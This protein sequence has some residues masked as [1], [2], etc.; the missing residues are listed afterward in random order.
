MEII[1]RFRITSVPELPL[2]RMHHKV[3]IKS[4][5]LDRYNFLGVSAK[6]ID[7]CIQD[8]AN[9]CELVRK[10]G[11][12]D[13]NIRY[14][15]TFRK[16]SVKDA[17]QLEIGQVCSLGPGAISVDGMELL[18]PYHN[19][20]LGNEENVKRIFLWHLHKF[21]RF[22]LRELPG[23]DLDSEADSWAFTFLETE[24]DPTITKA[25]RSASRW[26]YRLARNLG[27][28]KMTLR[29]RV[30]AGLPESSPCWQRLPHVETNTI[31]KKRTGV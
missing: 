24:A 15:L 11:K 19:P 1:K 8:G 28:R 6:N 21:Y 2:E 26:L 23:S 25:N 10:A 4:T 7:V 27:Y 14:R 5:V 13:G 20:K 16:F 3:R 18:F 12:Y 22:L 29:E 17:S 31:F 9:V 30:A